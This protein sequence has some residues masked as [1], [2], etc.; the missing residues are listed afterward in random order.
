MLA[1][2]GHFIARHRKAVIV[3]WAV[4]TAFGAF[5][6]GK[7]SKRWFQS[8]SIPG[9]AAYE[10][11]QQT[12]KVFGT[13]EQA[14]LVAVFH[15]RGDVT[16][17]AALQHAV[18]AGAAVNPGSR[19]SSYWTTH[20]LAYVSKDRHTA[21]AEIY[22]PAEPGF[23]SSVHVDSV[24]TKVQAATPPGVQSY[25][26]GR[27]ALEAASS[28]SKGPSVLTEAMIGGAGALLILFFVFGTLPAMLMPIAVAI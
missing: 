2:L 7:V 28:G 3:A 12:L 21:F 8:F 23:S 10:T 4:L 25:V 13:G 27:D 24:Q 16:K 20:D 5:S 26:T 9:Y 18:D 15:T 1:R 14:P 6:A 19:A 17:D 11:N 22:P